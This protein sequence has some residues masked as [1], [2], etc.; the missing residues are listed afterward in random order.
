MPICKTLKIAFGFYTL[1]NVQTALAEQE[2]SPDDV[3]SLLNL[4][5]KDLLNFEIYTA[6][7]TLEKIKNIPASV[8]LISR[9]NIE[10]YGYNTLT[11]VLENAP[12]LYN[13]YSYAGVSGNFGIRGFWNPL[14]QN[15]NV[16]F[17]V[18]G[19]RQVSD[20]DRSN[21]L[22][23]IN[24]PVEAID[25]IE[26]IRGPMAVLYGNGAAFGAINIITNEVNDNKNNSV[27]LISYGTNETKRTTL[28]LAN[29]ENNLRF[30]IN[31]GY[32]ATDGL[33]Y[34]LRDMMGPE[35]VASLPSLGVTDPDYRTNGLLGQNSKYF[36][37]SGSKNQ[38]LFDMAYNETQVG[39]F[40]LLPPLG[41]GYLRTSRNTSMMLGYQSD[42]SDKINLDVR[43]TYNSY[44]R[45]DIFEVL[46]AGVDGTQI[47]GYNSLELELL[48]AITP[49]N[50]LNIITGINIRNVTNLREATEA[51]SVGVVDGFYEK[52][53]QRTNAVFSQIT[54][55]A[56]DKLNLVAGI[57]FED[58][59]P[60][61]VNGI[62]NNGL[63]AQSTFGGR[64]GDIQSTSP[65][66]AA[67]YSINDQN[68]MKFLY[69]EANR[70]VNEKLK[71]E[72]TK[73][74]EINY[75]YSKRHFF[76][77]MSV[78]HNRLLDQVINDLVFEN[79][80]AASKTRNDG[81]IS[82]NGIEFI[83]NGNFSRYFFGEFSFTLQNSNNSKNSDIEVSYSPKTIAHAKLAYR[84][85][86]S[87]LAV[88]TR[89]VS[90]MQPLYDLTKQNPDGSYGAR[91]GNKVDP[92]FIVDFNIRQNN[93]FQKMYL[94][95]KV[96]NLFN[97]EVRYPNNQ[98]TNELLDRGTLGA[99]RMLIGS[100]GIM[101]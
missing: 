101:F 3:E 63:P 41:D 97:Q 98:E 33:D 77:S 36:N 85:S 25:R 54:Y 34:K 28:H 70:T 42:I 2:D 100:V 92:Y 93:V 44:S 32:Y 59:R 29:K 88:I 38:W 72:T 82:T 65:R 13:I 45:N 22:E 64:Q 7:K 56:T 55:Q 76:A 19:V 6:G 16:A 31:A 86:K 99:G 9:K 66:L 48:L 80:T 68:I 95:F 69:G 73:T 79:G 20:Y 15:S 18:N 8:I 4:S 51:P 74:S 1:L 67:I 81:G 94:N 78:F 84:N 27:G 83:S 10:K 62:E 35:N 14:S 52:T 90:S 57:R 43:G 46:V 11:E 37:V 49:N 61:Q 87:T 30:V 26:I 75:I 21:P 39:I 24:I 17:L 89:Y 47:I 58:L 71:A 91:V 5:L 53:D 40:L 12:G 50:Y 96:S 60:Y 23:K